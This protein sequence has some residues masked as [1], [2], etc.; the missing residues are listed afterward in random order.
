MMQI[1]VDEVLVT[2]DILWGNCTLQEPN[3]TLQKGKIKNLWKQWVALGSMVSMWLKK[4]L[5]EIV[6]KGIVFMN[7]YKNRSI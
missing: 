1:K 4:I 7:S 5:L 6:L 2:A 3:I